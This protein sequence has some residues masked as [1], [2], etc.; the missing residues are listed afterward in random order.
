MGIEPTRPAWKAG[1]LPLSYTRIYA[2]KSLTAFWGPLYC[3]EAVH[4]GLILE[5]KTGF[6]PAASTLARSHSTTESLPHIFAGAGEEA[7]TPMP[8]R[9]QILSLARLPIPPR[10][11]NKMPLI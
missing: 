9:H 6:E 3:P 4:R 5:R 2:P 1:T 8:L 11:L 10:P 7:R